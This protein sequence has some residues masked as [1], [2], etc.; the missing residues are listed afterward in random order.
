LVAIAKNEQLLTN[1]MIKGE[2]YLWFRLRKNNIELSETAKSIE[3]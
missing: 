3:W 1:T 2:E